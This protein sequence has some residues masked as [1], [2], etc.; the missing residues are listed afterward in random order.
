MWPWG[1]VAAPCALPHFAFF[2][3]GWRRN[4]RTAV[5]LPSACASGASMLFL[6]PALRPAWPSGWQRA[7]SAAKASGQAADSSTNL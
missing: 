7:R 4:L 2:S 6:A 5:L 1:G 3:F